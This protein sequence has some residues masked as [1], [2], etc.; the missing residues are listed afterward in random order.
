MI[1]LLSGFAFAQT[2]RQI[3][4]IR[5]EVAAINKSVKSY[6]KKVKD[7]DGVSLEGTQATYYTSNK[8]LKKITARM[9]GE[10][11]RATGELY[12]RGGELIFMY[13]RTNRYNGN[14]AMKPFPKIARVE[15]ERYY[16]AGGEL[17]RIVSGKRE[18]KTS[19]E[20]Y[21]ELKDSAM[22]ISKSLRDAY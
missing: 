13:V 15:E 7:V 11:F 17:V 9:Y 10:T 22:D 20:R 6:K 1:G 3:T 14:I 12:Y 19:D 21:A 8:G 18:L 5:A 4:A 2:G 16:F